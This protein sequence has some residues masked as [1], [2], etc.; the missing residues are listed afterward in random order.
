MGSGAAFCLPD[1]VVLYLRAVRSGLCYHKFPARGMSCMSFS[2]PSLKTSFISKVRWLLAFLPGE[3]INTCSSVLRNPTKSKP[4]AEFSLSS[5]HFPGEGQERQDPVFMRSVGRLLCMLMSPPVKWAHAG[6]V[7]RG[8]RGSAAKTHK[9]H[10][11]SSFLLPA[12][13]LFFQIF[14]DWNHF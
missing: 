2:T 8:A 10:R 14:S 7:I 11:M 9:R 13:S 4:F 1:N 6:P 12:L 5:H 3:T